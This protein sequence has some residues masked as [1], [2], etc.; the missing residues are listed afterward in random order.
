VT[1][2]HKLASEQADRSESPVLEVGPC[3]AFSAPGF[4]LRSRLPFFPAPKPGRI[5]C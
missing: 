1:P 5:R 3:G 2:V 4:S